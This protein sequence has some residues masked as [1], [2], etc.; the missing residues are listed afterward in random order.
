MK[1]VNILIFAMIILFVFSMSIMAEKTITLVGGT[2]QAEDQIYT[3]TLFKFKEL[4]SNYYD[5]PIEVEVHHSGDLGNEKDLFEFMMQGVSV[6]FGVI[7]PAWMTNWDQRAA[8]MEAP[9]IFRD[10]NHFSN[11]LDSGV[12][13]PIAEE[14]RK[15][16]VRFIGYGGGGSR[17]LILNQAVHNIDELQGIDLRVQGSPLAQKVWTAIGVDAT[18]LDYLETYNGIKTGVIDG[19]ENEPAGLKGMKFYEVAPFYVLSKH[20]IAPRILCFS[21]ARFQG[22]PEDLQKAILKAG[23]EAALFH[24]KTEMAEASIILDELTKKHGLTVIDFDNTEMRN[25]ALP[26]VEEYA[27]EI[28]AKNILESISKIK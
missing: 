9:F 5:G 7:S 16:G 17:N 8:I 21:E 11:A 27:D 23:R 6:D 20:T 26:I 2:M 24:R 15:K 3:R 12:F 25:R 18:P 4:V 1:K 13:E 14:I 19:L 22:F 28:N 10:E